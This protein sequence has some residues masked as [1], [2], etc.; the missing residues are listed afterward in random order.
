[1]DK[2]KYNHRAVVWHQAISQISDLMAL[3]ADRDYVTVSEAVGLIDMLKKLRSL[4]QRY[5]E[6]N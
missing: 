5:E 2:P 3:A 1:M 4:V 6:D